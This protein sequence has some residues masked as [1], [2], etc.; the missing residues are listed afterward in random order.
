MRF[1]CFELQHRFETFIEVVLELEAGKGN[2]NDNIDDDNDND[3]ND[4]YVDI[5]RSG[6]SNC[7]LSAAIFSCQSGQ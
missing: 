6:S 5:G 1:L 2:D 7:H 4:D 3:D